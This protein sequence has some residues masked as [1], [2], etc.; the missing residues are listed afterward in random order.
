MISETLEM[1]VKLFVAVVNDWK[2]SDWFRWYSN[3]KEKQGIRLIFDIYLM[4]F[5]I[6]YVVFYFFLQQNSCYMLQRS[7]NKSIHS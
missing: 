6:L 5:S 3:R 7:S 2:L 4:Y 1:F